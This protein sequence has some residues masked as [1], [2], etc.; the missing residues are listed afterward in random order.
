MGADK[1][2]KPR[3]VE[4]AAGRRSH[5]GSGELQKDLEELFAR[6][7][8]VL[9][10]RASRRVHGRQRRTARLQG[11]QEMVP[12]RSRVLGKQHLQES[13]LPIGLYPS[14]KVRQLDQI[15]HPRCHQSRH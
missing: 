8:F 10:K 5:R 14:V 11:G 4:T 6:I 13:G 12:A 9:R 7:E 1:G 15:R 2:Q 3:L